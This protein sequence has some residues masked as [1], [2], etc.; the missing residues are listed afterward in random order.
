MTLTVREDKRIMRKRLISVCIIVILV[1][2]IYGCTQTA[3]D[4][5]V[6][7]PE[8]VETEHTETLFGNDT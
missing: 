2:S 7:E 5:S 8:T 6:T 4:T 3:E 1:C